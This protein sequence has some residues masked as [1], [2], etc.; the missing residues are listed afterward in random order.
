MVPHQLFILLWSGAGS[1]LNAASVSDGSTAEVSR[2]QPDN[3]HHSHCPSH[4]HLK[5]GEAPHHN[6]TKKVSSS[7]PSAGPSNYQHNMFSFQ[8]SARH[9]YC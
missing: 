7:L 8:F 6:N 4:G 3:P 9:N 5:E 2:H 1:S